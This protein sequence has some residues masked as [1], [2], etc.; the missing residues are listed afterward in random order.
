M[1][2]ESLITKIVNDTLDKEAPRASWGAPNTMALT[3]GLKLSV[4]T[5]LDGHRTLEVVVFRPMNY[6]Q[7]WSRLLSTTIPLLDLE[8][9]EGEGP[10]PGKDYTTT[11][12]EWTLHANHDS[13]WRDGLTSLLRLYDRE[14]LCFAGLGAWYKMKNA[15]LLN[16]PDPQKAW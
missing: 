5:D 15:A 9:E 10:R 8:D 7:V 13:C 1:L 6:T 12:G 3:I 16:L 4:P 11:T 14:I 2:S